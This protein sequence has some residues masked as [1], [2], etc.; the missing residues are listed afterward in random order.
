MRRDRNHPSVILWSVGNEVPDQS[1]KDGPAIAAE[2]TKIAHDEDG[3]DALSRRTVAACDRTE[4][5]FNDFHKGLDVM[6]FNYKPTVYNRFRQANPD[7]PVIGTETSSCVSSRGFYTFPV[8]DNKGGGQADFQVSDYDLYAPPWATPPDAEFRGQ[9]DAPFTG[10]EFVWTGFDYLGEPTPYNADTTNLLNFQDPVERAKMAGQL[11]AL[12]KLEVPSRSSYF[13]IVD[14]AGFPKNRYY[15]YQAR[16]RAGLPMAH[17]LPHWTWPDRVGEVT[18]VMVFTSGDEA[19]LF[20]NGQSLGRQKKGPRE[21]RLRW[22]DVK[23]AP[24]EL[25]VVAYKDGK[26]WATD[27]V[28]TAAAPAKI[29]LR[30]EAPEVQADGKNLVFVDATITDQNGTPVPRTANTLKFTVTGPARIVAT[31]NGD[32]TS[33]ASFQSPGCKAFDGKCLVILRTEAGATGA[34]TVHADAEGLQSAG[35]TVQ[36]Q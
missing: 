36:G 10:G 13:G 30:A 18:P 25:K 8:T 32:A 3:G 7:Q 14:L 12:G 24:G 34:I 22:D 21:Y 6:G 35:A 33:H 5:G 27:T 31:D 19:E 26:E 15:E 1:T 29:R 11:K 16:W 20:L 9:D 23:Y 2:L 28:K 4:S 17:L